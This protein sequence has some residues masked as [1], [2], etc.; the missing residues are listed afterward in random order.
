VWG[1]TLSGFFSP[2]G[3]NRGMTVDE[4]DDHYIVGNGLVS[5]LRVR[6]PPRCPAHVRLPRT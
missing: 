1:E 6:V 2:I 3:E 4:G 5:R